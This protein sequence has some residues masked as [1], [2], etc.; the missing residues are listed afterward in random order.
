MKAERPSTEPSTRSVGFL[1]LRAV[2]ASNRLQPPAAGQLPVGALE[3]SRWRGG[4][5]F[6]RV[7][8]VEQE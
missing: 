2:L 1:V 8:E 6:V 4:R 7:C 5:T 3:L